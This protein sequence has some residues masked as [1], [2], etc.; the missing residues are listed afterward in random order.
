V[1]ISI[2]IYL[3][4][5]AFLTRA[6][7]GLKLF[8]PMGIGFAVVLL[9]SVIY[10]ALRGGLSA[11]WDVAFWYNFVYSSVAPMERFNSLQETWTFL[12][13]RS[14]FFLLALMAWLAGL[15]YVFLHHQP[16]RWVITRR[17]MG[18]GFA[19]AGLFLLYNGLFVRS[20]QMYAFS[21]LSLYR[22][23]LI[24]AG[25][26]LLL[27]SITYASGWPER[28]VFPWLEALSPACDSLVLLPLYLALVDLLLNLVLVSL[29]GRGYL[30]Y[31]LSLFPSLTLLTAFL[32]FSFQEQIGQPSARP[33]MAW[34]W[35]T[36][37]LLPLVW[38]GAAQTVEKIHP[39][40]DLQS[41][42]AVAY[43]QANT[44]PDDSI[45]MWGTQTTIYY[46]ANREA[47][48]R[49]VH[50]IPLFNPSYATADRLDEF[51]KDLET[52][53]P[54][55]IIDTRLKNLPLLYQMGSPAA[56]EQA[57]PEDPNVA[58]PA[59]MG[60]VYAFICANYEPVGPLGKDNWL[61]Y[62][63]NPAI[64]PAGTTK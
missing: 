38:G 16:A 50:Q 37:L 43:I 25:L 52:R 6:W 5:A 17:W 56:C 42:Q 28:R 64:Q 60:K 11:Y 21:A 35:S 49:Y 24:G 14:G 12:N 39:G 19:V 26:L 29:S 34:V 27:V 55:L 30:H 2:V 47:P 31:N 33:S 23:G 51:L 8:L 59:G 10:F 41:T 44:R 3:L 4:S 36:A 57:K 53:K 62:R 58:V 40:S 18:I 7:R 54:A 32:V 48:T 61:V 13:T 45:L 63:Y 1:W 22:W 15:V 9:V 46:L 20:F